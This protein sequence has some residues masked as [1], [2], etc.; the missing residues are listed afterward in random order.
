MSM[1][2]M[3]ENNKAIKDSKDNKDSK[4]KKDRPP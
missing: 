2:M 4:D 3:I 1:L